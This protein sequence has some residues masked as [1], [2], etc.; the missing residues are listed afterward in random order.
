MDMVVEGEVTREEEEVTR[1][2]EEVRSFFRHALT[3]TLMILPLRK[4][5]EPSTYSPQTHH[6]PVYHRPSYN[7]SVHHSSPI[8]SSVYHSF[9][10]QD[11]THAVVGEGATMTVEEE[12]VGM[13]E[14]GE[15]MEEE[16]VTAV[17]VEED[18][19]VCDI[20]EYTLTRMHMFTS[21][22]THRHTH[23]IET[24]AI[25]SSLTLLPPCSSQG[26]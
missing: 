24:V 15:A 26:L 4:K 8:P 12:G 5:P 17:G 16:V 23:L 1:E 6:S 14:E 22:R 18:M 7:C 9:A 21:I 2:E 19:E 13:E 11:M 20:F 10:V 3:H 25:V